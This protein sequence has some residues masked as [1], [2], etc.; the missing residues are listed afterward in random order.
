M[1][2]ILNSY[3]LIVDIH[4]E[5]NMKYKNII[6]IKQTVSDGFSQFTVQGI[7]VIFMIFGAVVSTKTNT[8]AAKKP[9]I[10]NKKLKDKL[11]EKYLKKE[12]SSR[13]RNKHILNSFIHL[14]IIDSV[15]TGR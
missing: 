10:C 7:R 4:K 8:N 11:R 2:L 6:I 3:D 9:H 15:K 14:R 13:T 5:K 12:V 1:S